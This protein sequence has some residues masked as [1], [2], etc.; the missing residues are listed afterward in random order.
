MT[1]EASVDKPKL[2]VTY[3]WVDNENEDVDFY[4]ERL[5]EQA[6]V[7]FDRRSVAAGKRH[8]E[9]FAEQISKKCDAWV[10]LVSPS[11]LANERWREEA[12]YALD[13][14]LYSGN[15][16][17][18]LLFLVLGD[19]RPAED[20]PEMMRIRLY[21]SVSEKN[22][23]DKIIAG[24]K[25]E[26]AQFVHK[27]HAPFTLR[28]HDMGNGVISIEVRLRE[29]TWPTWRVFEPAEGASI[30][31]VSAC[32]PGTPRTYGIL[33]SRRP[34]KIDDPQHGSIAL[35]EVG[36]PAVS[37]MHSAY[38]EAKGFLAIGKARRRRIEE[39][40]AA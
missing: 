39:L 2:W 26:A 14:A 25:G 1:E 33:S 29:G 13:R 12:F 27:T 9:E 4:I 8:W 31:K 18:P 22:W 20:L 37:P 24:A 32:A 38:I 34:N 40:R 10:G 23:R 17:F 7:H 3:V 35:W 28:A 6:D 36:Q 5:Q 19:K 11:S 15:K 30:V 16:R 21:V